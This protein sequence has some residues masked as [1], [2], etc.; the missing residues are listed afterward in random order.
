MD[1]SGLIGQKKVIRKLTESIENDTVGHAYIFHGPGGIGKRTLARAFAGLL[2]C[3]MPENEGRNACNKCI[4]CNLSN[5]GTNPDLTVIEDD[6]TKIGVDEIRK[7]QYDVNKRPMYSQRKVYLIFKAEKMTEQAQNCLLKTLE[8]PPS[9]CVIILTAT[10]PSKLLSTVTSRAHPLMLERYSTDEIYGFLVEK[11]NIDNEKADF[12][13][14]YSDGILGKAVELAFDEKL[15]SIREQV[16]DIL[17]YL[18]KKPLQYI[19]ETVDFFKNNKE[20]FDFIFDMISLFFRDI[21]SII[22]YG[23]E[24]RL[25]NID[26]KD[27]ILNNM[28]FFTT[29]KAVN[30]ID[31]VEKTRTGIKKY[32]NFQLSIEIMLMKLSGGL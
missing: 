1:F 2:L 9:Y 5:S 20:H 21:L 7:I 30:A 27:I 10:N 29:L 17:I 19:F 14:R 13:T 32:A 23:N 12:L 15:Y 11:E 4:S 25:I 31:I 16:F 24:K 3:N 6:G 26:K 22:H 8:E 28:S 18:N